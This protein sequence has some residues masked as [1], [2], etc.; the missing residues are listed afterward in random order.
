VLEFGVASIFVVAPVF[1]GSFVLFIDDDNHFD[2]KLILE[3]Q[4][5]V[6]K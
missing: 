3:S 5:D 6:K 2:R 4:I 1:F